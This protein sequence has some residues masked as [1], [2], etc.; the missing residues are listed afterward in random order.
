MTKPYHYAIHCPSVR[1]RPVEAEIT[2]NGGTLLFAEADRYLDLTRATGGAHVGGNASRGAFRSV[3]QCAPPPVASGVASGA[4]LINDC[5]KEH[6]QETQIGPFNGPRRLNP[7]ARK[8]LGPRPPT[9]GRTSSVLPHPKSSSSPWRRRTSNPSSINSHGS[10]LSR[11]RSSSIR[12]PLKNLNGTR[13]P[14]MQPNC[15]GS[16]AGK[17]HWWNGIFNALP[18]PTL[19]SGSPWRFAIAMRNSRRTPCPP[20]RYSTAFSNS[21]ACG[22]RR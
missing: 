7:T 22:V 11:A 20:T 4:T 8:H 18:Y 19:G 13:S 2:A 16:A 5:S 12:P 6:R 14:S 17:D 15:R 21:R 3:C 10:N 1:W 9:H